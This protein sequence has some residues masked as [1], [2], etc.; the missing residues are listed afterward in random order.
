[1]LPEINNFLSVSVDLSALELRIL[2]VPQKAVFKSAIGTRNSKKALIIKWITNDGVIGY[3]ECSC[4]SDP[5]YSHEYVDGAIQVI[6]S[7][8]F[9]MLNRENIFGQVLSNLAKIR[10][11]NFTK[12]AVGFAMNDAVRRTVGGGMIEASGIEAVDEV[13]VGISLGLFDNVNVME[14][15][16]QS[17]IDQGYKRLKFKISPDYND[18]EI[19]RAIKNI[20]FINISFDANG[21][22]SAESFKLLSSF[23]ELGY[24][25]EQPFAPGDAY[26][27]E[28][29]NS[30]HRPIRLCLDEEIVSVGSL[31]SY[32][33]DLE[34]VNIKPGRIGGLLNTLEMIDYCA[35]AAIP[36][37]IGGMFETGIGRAQNLQLA[38]L[39]PGAKA[40]DQSPSTRYFE[41]DVLKMP[42]EMTNGLI[43]S[44]YFNEVEIDEQVFDAMTIYKKVLTR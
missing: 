29:Y 4:R 19:F 34:E 21:S 43:G 9:P 42:I 23:A 6:E 15:A 24:V 2:E 31:R 14:N 12:A 37:W 27:M 22:F 33:G 26:L 11:W 28:L 44:E 3:G 36:A 30:S 16:V 8:I 18:P 40:H 38:A 20:N 32:N 25:I 41:Q 35:A 5:F 17:A 39:L 1:L 10:G 7:F 13:P